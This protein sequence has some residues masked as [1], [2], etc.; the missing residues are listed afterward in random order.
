LIPDVAGC[1]QPAR[2]GWAVAPPGLSTR[3]PRRS[4]RRLQ[5]QAEHRELVQALKRRDVH[6]ARAV[7][8]EHLL[9][10]QR[11]LLRP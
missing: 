3:P 11:N 4:E 5:Y 7:A 1:A 2:C 8:T 6:Q 10:V 9:R